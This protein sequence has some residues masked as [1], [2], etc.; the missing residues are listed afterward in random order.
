VDKEVSGSH[1]TQEYLNRWKAYNGYC[2]SNVLISEPLPH[3]AEDF[4]AM[5]RLKMKVAVVQ[6]T[7]YTTL[8]AHIFNLRLTQQ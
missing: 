4:Q 1:L 8:T 7:G 3:R 5:S 2:H 6:L